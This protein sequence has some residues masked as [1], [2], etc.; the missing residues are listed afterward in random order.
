M[1]ESRFEVRILRSLG[2]LPFSLRNLAGSREKLEKRRKG[3]GGV[4][5]EGVVNRRSQG[6]AHL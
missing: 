2:L 5:I 1:D 6:G 4:Y 3:E